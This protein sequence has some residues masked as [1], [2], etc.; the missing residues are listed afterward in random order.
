MPDHF[1]KDCLEAH[2]Q[3][4]VKHGAPGLKW[5][6]KLASDAEEWAKE[7]L[8]KNKLQHSS[9]DYGENLAFASGKSNTRLLSTNMYAWNESYIELGINEW[10]KDMSIA[11]LKQFLSNCNASPEKNP[12]LTELNP[13]PPRYGAMLQPPLVCWFYPPMKRKTRRICMYQ[14]IRRL[15]G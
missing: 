6:A 15:T 10:M 2:N 9:G 4:R 1:Q 11:V 14:M 12:D 3:Y 13:W 8:N 7:L 5:S